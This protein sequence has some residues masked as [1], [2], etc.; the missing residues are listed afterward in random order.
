[1]VFDQTVRLV[2]GNANT[3]QDVLTKSGIHGLPI[4]IYDASGNQITSFS[5]GAVTQGTSPWVISGNVVVTS[6]PPVTIDTTG[7]ATSAKQDTGNTSL[8]SIDGKITAVNTGAVVLA[9]GTATVGL[10]ISSPQ[11]GT[12]FVGTATQTIVQA[13]VNVAASQTDSAI[14]AASGTKVIYVL[15]VALVSGGTATN[16]TFGSKPVGASTAI[17]PLFANAAN[18]GA[19]LPFNPGCWFKTA[20]GEGLCVTTGAGSTTGI[21]VTYI[22]V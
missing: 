6:M 16:V 11:V 9:A 12:G 19:V 20:A 5:G 1:M 4:F 10:A 22:I 3:Q 7:L 8:S 18:G 17:S 13:F 21:L 15:S 2:G 14:V